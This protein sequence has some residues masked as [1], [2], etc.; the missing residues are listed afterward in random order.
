MR[1]AGRTVARTDGRRLGKRPNTWT[2]PEVL[3]DVVSVSDPDS[4]RMNASLGYVQGDNAQ[5]VVDE[6]QIV[7]AAEIIRTLGD[8]SNLDPMITTP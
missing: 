4:Q 5:A 1:I 6:G 8:C 7:I 3:D 2:A